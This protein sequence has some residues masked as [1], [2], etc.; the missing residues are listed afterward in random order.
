VLKFFGVIVGDEVEYLP[1][2]VRHRLLP[3][4]D[5]EKGLVTEKTAIFF[6]HVDSTHLKNLLV[7][8]I[9]LHDSTEE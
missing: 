5:G 2:V 7:I 9:K 6:H 3:V 4:L 1:W 8:Q